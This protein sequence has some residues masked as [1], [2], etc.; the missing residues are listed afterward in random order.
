MNEDF[1]IVPP[2]VVI[3]STTKE[4]AYK[5]KFAYVHKRYSQYSWLN[6][7]D[8]NGTVLA[9]CFNSKLTRIVVIRQLK[10]NVVSSPFPCVYYEA[11]VFKSGGKLPKRDYIATTFASAVRAAAEY[12]RKGPKSE[13]FRIY[14]D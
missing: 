11:S 12:V 4:V 9:V 10:Y 3:G 2:Y 1:E 8:R 6:R 7:P 14:E 13:W 5:V